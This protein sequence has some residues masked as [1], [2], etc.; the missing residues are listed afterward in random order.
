M[1]AWDELPD[2]TAA[3]AAALQV[4]LAVDGLYELDFAQTAEM[5]LGALAT[6]RAVGDRPLVAAAASVLCLGEAAAGHTA[7][8]LERR[9]EAR[10]AVDGLDDPELAPRVEALYYLGWAETYLERYDEAVAHFERGVAIARE[11]GDGRLLV[12]MM[13]GKNFS[14][15]MTGRLAEASELCETALE[16]A[17][18]TASPH[19][20]YRALF[21]LGWTRYYAGDLD[22]ALA[23]FEESA[24]V[25]PRLAGGTIPNAGGGPGWG[26][27][28]ALLETGEVER[29]RGIL[30]GLVD[31][32]DLA[33][34]MPVERC[35]D[36]ESL[37]LVELAAGNVEAADAFAR[38]AEEDA[39]RLGLKLPAALAA[40]T[41]AAVLL[42]RGE[43]IDAASAAGA[44]ADAAASIGARLQSAFSRGLQG[45][46][47]WP[48]ASARRRSRRC[49]RRRPSSTRAARCACATSCAAS[50][51]S[52][53]PAASRAG[54][55]RW[56]RPGSRR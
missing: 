24:R 42:A 3:A 22:A 25:D 35:F 56:A 44:S 2:R 31:A 29:G 27:G 50:C 52:S 47:S 39:E 49:A 41:R 55:R 18:L 8:A 37:A 4:E 34:T 12:L 53:A 54:P 1:R 45:A 28:V 46:R 16:A 13:L 43:A 51:A 7:L 33:R 32:D 6:A 5:G 17:R 48:R 23:A 40:R 21:E 38:R 26:L 20:L 10:A 30:L 11:S 9:E 14:F 15:E 19:E 36:W